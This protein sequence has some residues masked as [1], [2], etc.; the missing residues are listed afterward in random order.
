MGAPG[1]YVTNCFTMVRAICRGGFGNLRFTGCDEMQRPR[2]GVAQDSARGATFWWVLRQ[3]REGAMGV[4]VRFVKEY[5]R[6][7][8]GIGVFD[9][10]RLVLVGLVAL[11]VGLFCAGV[12]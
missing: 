1:A 5:V 9:S 2:R 12:A 7:L 10:V 3:L 6:V 4:W 11:V 8:R